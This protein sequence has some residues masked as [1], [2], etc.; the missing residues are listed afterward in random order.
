MTFSIKS[1]F[2]NC[3]NCKL[4]N[5][6]SCILET[7]CKTNLEDVEVIF[8]SENPGKIE[9]NQGIPLIGKNNQSFRKYFD[10]YIKKDFKWLITNVVLCSTIINAEGIN[11]PPEKD[12]IDIC[13]ENCFNIIRTCK[14][15]LIVLLGASAMYAF[16]LG[17]TGIINM[18]GQIFKWEEFDLF[19]TLHPS[20]INKAKNYEE[21]YE[22]DFKKISEILG[23]DIK[24]DDKKIL[25][26]I[27]SERHLYSIPEKF[28][29]SDYKLID[30]QFLNKESKVLY[31]FRD[32]DNNKIYHKENDEYVCYQLKDNIK[33]KKV[34][35][36]DN[37][38]QI[39]IP[40]KQKYS[41]N[42][43]KTYEGDLKL[44]VKHAIDYYLKKIVEE[45]VVPLNII[46][47]DI[48]TFSREKSFSGPEEARDIIVMVTFKYHGEKITYVVDPKAMDSSNTQVITP[49]PNIVICNSEKNLLT[50]CVQ[51]L[52]NKD[53]DF[54][55]GWN[56]N[57]FDLPYIINRHRKNNMDFTSI[58]KF[59]QVSYETYSRYVDIAGYICLDM[60]DLFKQF[61]QNKKESYSLN[62]ISNDELKEGK[63]ESSSSFARLYLTEIDRAIAYNIQDVEL[64]DKL[65]IKLKHV[66]L[67]DEI[68]KICKSNF[69]ASRSPM[70]QL[71]SL[72]VSYLKEKGLS[73]QNAVVQEKTEAFEGAFVKEPITGI[74]S[75]IVDFDFTSLYPSIIMTLNIGV[76][77][78][79]M[80]LKD[81]KLGYELVYNQDKLPEQIEVIVDPI[82]NPETRLVKKEDLLK[83][84]KE[85]NL[86]YSINGCFFKKNEISFYSDILKGLISSRK[87]YKN[88]MFKAKESKDEDKEQLFNIRQLVYKVLANSLYG[89][90][91]NK[92]FRFF[93]LDC[94]RTIT[95]TGQEFIKNSIIE[96]DK[97][98][99]FLGSG[100]H[101]RPKPLIK[102]EVYGEMNRETKNV[103]T[104]DTDSLFAT[105]EN[106]LFGDQLNNIELINEYSK[107]VQTFLNSQLITEL[108][109]KHNI[110]LSFNKLELKNELV[111]KRGLYVSKKHYVNYV[112]SQ[113]GVKMDKNV[114]MGLDTKRSDISAI[115]KTYLKK[116]YDLILREEIFSIN[117]VEKFIKDVEIIF[118]EKVNSG[119]KEI[120]KSA[121]WGKELEDYKTIPQGVRG[122][123]H[124]NNLVYNIFAS[125]SKG[126]LFNVKGL[127]LERAP[128]E[129][130]ENYNKHFLSKGLKL[131]II[132]VPE[133]EPRL[134][135]YFIV[136]R[137]EM[138]D[139]SWIDRHEI[140]LKPLIHVKDLTGKF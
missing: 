135:N 69:R 20:F 107:K 70:G 133:D 106:I 77:T 110:D 28:Y 44:T 47:L 11:E 3:M 114:E 85:S 19:L 41:L 46:F 54:I 105:Y 120:A 27:V 43:E 50:K 75:A 51:Y 32:K 139:K 76:N 99:D 96:A 56:S 79:C 137:K 124:W 127:D 58:S 101:E 102:S 66:M 37:L 38:Y 1:S 10:K 131:D 90:L 82:N 62:F 73:S 128:K 123:I 8:I 16:G 136:D 34:L 91:G 24:N 86:A 55:C 118:N 89:I 112:V 13:K 121:S 103:V 71:D 4:L 92:V 119:S 33:A 30:V 108:L 111:I 80:K 26:P 87:D 95:L 65:N 14:P 60:M 113:E 132:V 125:G 74:H 116:L 7:N 122:M 35:E 15:K 22:E 67:Q 18:R 117:K 52:R 81:Y 5:A 45:P 42:P 94:A 64:L 97:F 88:K 17:E 126:Y 31:I 84:I 23:F 12:I 39:K 72:V 48:E 98:V 57:G 21:K 109:Q 29:T 63:S 36:Y 59:N 6:P 78:F 93:N 100:K 129:V 68:R 25:G 138:L 130:Q 104:G 61:T 53:A 9:T 140:L 83:K 40:Y 115:T 134:P 2:A 49:N